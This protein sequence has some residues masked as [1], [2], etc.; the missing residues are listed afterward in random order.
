M[1]N[2]KRFTLIELLVVIAII[3]ILAAML[4]PALD[5]AR[6]RGRAIYCLNNTKQIGLGMLMY[7]DDADETQVRYLGATPDVNDGA[8]PVLIDKYIGGTW[9]QES[10]ESTANADRD[11]LKGST[12]SP[13]WT[14]CP[15]H[16][17]DPANLP[18]T[19][20]G[21]YVYQ[22]DY[23]TPF[24]NR[25]GRDDDTTMLG[26]KIG[27]VSEPETSAII[28]DAYA[29][30]TPWG[31]YTGSSSINP[32]LDFRFERQSGF[33]FGVSRHMN[34]FTQSVT[35]LDGHAKHHTFEPFA[36]AQPK[37]F[38]FHTNGDISY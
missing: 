27:A 3:A 35:F 13:M 7:A 34:N 37:L 28:M 24:H 16:E 25:S 17:N 31:Y 26:H 32:E 22:P 4:L 15:S 1:N 10:Y 33:G 19:W 14:A 36:V 23:G 2:N 38:S 12:A 20:K 8:W 29:H 30:W 21:N 18:N 11:F 6:Q 9:D 5:G